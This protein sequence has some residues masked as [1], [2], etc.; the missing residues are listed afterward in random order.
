LTPEP[1]QLVAEWTAGYRKFWPSR[2][3]LLGAYLD[4]KK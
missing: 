4:A 3:K 2:L 1:L